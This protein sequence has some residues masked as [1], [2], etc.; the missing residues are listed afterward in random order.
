MVQYG[1]VKFG[2]FL[3]FATYILVEAF[4]FIVSWIRRAC[5]LISLRSYLIYSFVIASVKTPLKSMPLKLIPDTINPELLYALARMGH[6][7]CICIADANFPSDTVAKS[8]VIK[9]PIRVRG[10][11]TTELLEDILKLMPV[12][13]YTDTP[14]SVMDRVPHDKERDLHVPCYDRVAQ[15]TLLEKEKLNYIERFEFYNVAKKCFA[16][17]QTDDR[18]LYANILLS[19]GVL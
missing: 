16:V 18:S 1:E 10:V 19:K 9:E 6:G 2:L 11:S 8:C 13:T 4:H 14:V 5:A 17:V 7:D 12:D 3:R 15:V